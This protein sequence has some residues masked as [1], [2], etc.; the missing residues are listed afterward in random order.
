[1]DLNNLVFST[2]DVSYW[3]SS[4]RFFLIYTKCM[5]NCSKDLQILCSPYL[6]LASWPFLN[7][8]LITATVWLGDNPGSLWLRL[9]ISWTL[10]RRKRVAC[11]RLKKMTVYMRA[12]NTK[13]QTNYSLEQTY[14][15]AVGWRNF[16]RPC[17]S[18]APAKSKLM[19]ITQGRC[20]FFTTLHRLSNTIW[21]G[22]RALRIKMS[23]AYG[24]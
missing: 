4:K 3:N 15:K 9:F 10:K 13:H 24:R 14:L 7:W 17:V 1:M 23:Q 22:L 19:W 18:L 2:E 5:W 6:I 8:Q 16:W 11:S 20:T 12:T 21:K